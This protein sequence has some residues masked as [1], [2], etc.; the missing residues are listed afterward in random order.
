MGSP[1]SPSLLYLSP[2]LLAFKF[3][4]FV[5]LSY[6][7]DA[8]VLSPAIFAACCKSVPCTARSFLAALPFPLPLHLLITGEPDLN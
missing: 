8:I 2:F 1:I 4:S 7:L 3:L 5:V 6:L